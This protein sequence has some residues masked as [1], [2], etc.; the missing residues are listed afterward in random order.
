SV[1]IPQIASAAAISVA[2]GAPAV[3]VSFQ[4]P[5]GAPLSNSPVMTG[6][7]SAVETLHLYNVT[8]AD[9]GTWHL[10][11]T[12]PANLASELV[13]ATVFW[14]GAV[15]ALT[16]VSPPNAK[17]GQQVKVTLDVLGPNGP[18]TD[19]ATISSMLVGETVTGNG[20]AGTVGVPVT[21]VSGSPGE[22]SG[23]YTVPDQSTTLTF[24]GTASGYGLYTTE[25]SATVGVG[26]QSQGLTATPDFTGGNSVQAGGTI[27]GQV[28]LTNQ[29]GSAQH[30]KLEVTASGATVALTSPNGPVTVASGSPPAV[31]FAINVAKDSP[32]GTAL[33]QVTAVN[34]ATGQVINTAQQNFTITKP[35]G[36]L[37]RYWWLLPAL[38]VIIVLAVLA[39]KTR[40][41]RKNVRGLV[42]MLRKGG[43]PTGRDLEVDEKY[44]EVLSFIIRDEASPAPRLDHPGKGSSVGVYQVRRAGRGLVRLTTPTGLRPSEVEVGGAGLELGNGLQLAFRDARHPDWTGTGRIES[45]GGPG[46]WSGSGPGTAPPTNADDWSGSAGGGGATDWSGSGTY[47]GTANWAGGPSYGA[48]APTAPGTPPPPP[49]PRGYGNAMPTMP[50]GPPPP[51]PPPPPPSSPD[52]WA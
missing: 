27:P 36:F 21:A 42:A 14:Q 33:V 31:P 5:S 35:P 39:W 49:P 46:D 51:P 10:T 17:L 12:A 26:T 25:V 8:A 50:M 30:V 3:S 43:V 45:V 48:A 32:I 7:G 18:I 22:W 20:L 34:A 24:A 19:P 11:L 44:S 4:P 38:V 13:R 23:V 28:V 47:S 16:T 40:R 15:R 29:T 9:V 1:T 37:A 6:E 41:D 52:P 2:R